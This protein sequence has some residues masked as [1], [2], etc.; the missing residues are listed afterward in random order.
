M[1]LYYKQKLRQMSISFLIIDESISLKMYHCVQNAFIVYGYYTWTWKETR[2]FIHKD[3]T[4]AC[5]YD[6]ISWH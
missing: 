4:T 3:L 6:K 5:T 2:C 1:S